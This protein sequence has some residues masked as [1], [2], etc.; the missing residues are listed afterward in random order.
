MYT[1]LSATIAVRHWTE[2]V[3]EKWCSYSSTGQT[4]TVR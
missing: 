3:S 4:V 2:Q 1:M